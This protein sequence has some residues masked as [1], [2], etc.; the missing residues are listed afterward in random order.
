MGISASNLPLLLPR[1][2]EGGAPL[3]RYV[4]LPRAAARADRGHRVGGRLHAG[5]LFEEA[6]DAGALPTAE[7]PAPD[8]SYP[9]T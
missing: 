5:R 4:H 6:A 8:W 3:L 1:D 9:F 7:H 2:G